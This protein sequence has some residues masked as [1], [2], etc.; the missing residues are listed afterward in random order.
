MYPFEVFFIFSI[1]FLRFI[2]AVP[3]ITS[4][5]P[6]YY[7]VVYYGTVWMYHD[8]FNQLTFEGHI[9]CFQDRAIMNKDIVNI[10]L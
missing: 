3:Y 4:S 8:L 6:F 9:S 1:I 2:Q 10:H 7:W 5:V